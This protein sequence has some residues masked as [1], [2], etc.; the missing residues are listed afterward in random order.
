MFKLIIIWYTGEREEHLFN[1]RTKAERAERGYYI[2][3]GNQIDF[4][5]VIDQ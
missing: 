3:F 5:C 2:A 4:T 1:T